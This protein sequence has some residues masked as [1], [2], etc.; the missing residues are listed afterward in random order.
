MRR[1]E[2]GEEMY[3]GD[4]DGDFPTLSDSRTA[5][6]SRTGGWTGWHK[7]GNIVVL[8]IVM[9]LCVGGFAVVFVFLNY[10]CKMT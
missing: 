1:G 8:L 4:M 2:A 6:T 5:V 3:F 9:P 7:S 10:H